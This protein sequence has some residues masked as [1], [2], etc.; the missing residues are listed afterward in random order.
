MLSYKSLGVSKGGSSAA[1]FLIIL[2]TVFIVRVIAILALL[3]EK[4][5]TSVPAV[6]FGQGLSLD[7]GKS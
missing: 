1:T 6:D 3:F 4:D 2:H 7:T 5:I